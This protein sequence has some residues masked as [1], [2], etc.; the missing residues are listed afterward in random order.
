MV[1]TS[2]FVYQNILCL[3]CI[4]PPP[5][6]VFSSLS[7]PSLSPLLSSCGVDRYVTMQLQRLQSP[8][9]RPVSESNLCLQDAVN[10]CVLTWQKGRRKLG[11]PLSHLLWGRRPHLWEQSPCDKHTPK[12]STH[13]L[14]GRPG[15]EHSWGQHFWWD[16][17]STLRRRVRIQRKEEMRMWCCYH[18]YFKNAV[19]R[20][21]Y[22]R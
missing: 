12:T 16:M 6:Y 9:H 17:V 13:G 7:P 10:C 2:T 22:S 19:L 18:Y 4:H 11:C 20:A 1:L 5:S 15:L 8:R 3:D 14:W 21:L